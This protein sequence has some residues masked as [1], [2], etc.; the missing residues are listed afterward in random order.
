MI[1][2]EFEQGTP[3]WHEIRH[4]K[5]GGT[6]SKELLIESDTLLLNI[7]AERLE[8]YQDDDS[9]ESSA[10]MRGKELEPLARRELESYTGISFKE[11]G[12][13]QC[14]EN[15]LLGVSKDGLS[16]CLT[17]ACEIKCPS[18]K[19][20]LD[21]VLG[22]TVPREHAG[23]CI[24]YFTINPKL[25]TLYF[26]SFRPENKIKPLFVVEIK[27]D[28]LIDVG[29]KIKGKVKEDRGLGLKEYVCE[30]PDLKTVDEWSK[31]TRLRA[32]QILLKSNQIIESLKF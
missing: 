27:R 28:T 17:K 2:T 32:D 13:I 1:I 23:Q 30:N 4:A 8:D 9:F 12:W 25:E 20:H 10:M 15:E 6:R 18:A 26:A 16:K 14:E 29:H 22:G 11:F 31:L 5:I 3:E 7:T 21:Y 24:H 19:V